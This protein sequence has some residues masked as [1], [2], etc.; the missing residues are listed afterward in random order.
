MAQTIPEWTERSPADI[1]VTVVELLAFAADQL[2]YYQ[3]SVANETY[4]GTARRRPSLRRHARLLDYTPREG[5]N[6]RTF[7]RIEV[8][9]ASSADGAQLPIHTPL[10][11]K[12][13]GLTTT[14]V[15]AAAIDVALQAGSQVFE[16]MESIT[17]H[18]SHDE[19]SIYTWGDEDCCLPKGAV[20]ATLLNQDL[21]V[22]PLDSGAIKVGALLAF[23][24]VNSPNEGAPPDPQHRH[25]VRLT[26]VRTTTDPLEGKQLVEIEWAPDDALP[27][28]LCVRDLSS[29]VPVSVVQGNI[30]LADHGHSVTQDLPPPSA[31]RGNQRFLPHLLEGPI[32]FQAQVLDAGQNPILF[33]PT[34]PATAALRG[35]PRLA[36]PAVLLFP[37]RSKGPDNDPKCDRDLSA[38]TD[39]WTPVR[40]LLES[41]PFSQSF[42]VE[43]ENDGTA[44]LRFGDDILGQTPTETLFACYRVG[45]GAAGNIGSGGLSHIVVDLPGIVSVSNVVAATGG[46]D[47]EPLQ[48]IQLNAPQAFRVQERAVTPADYTDVA[49]R[50]PGVQRAVATLRFTGSWY[51]MFV[52]VDRLGG[53]PVDD[54]FKVDFAN[55]LERFRLAGYDLEIQGAIPVPLDVKLTACVLPGFLRSNVKKALL[56]ALSNRDLPDGRRGF[57]HPDNFTFGQPVFLSQLVAVALAVPGVGAIDTGGDNLVFKRLRRLPDAASG[58]GVLKMQRLE[59]AQL[60]NDPSQPEH[61]KLAL[62]MQGGGA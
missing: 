62:V 47:P 53:A 1:G 57:F 52:A 43:M 21:I 7:V 49:K 33:D 46:E 8:A 51:T 31:V 22:D 6:A 61:G 9:P 42:V 3:D 50:H 13:D 5:A 25:V 59:I 18:G 4:L 34:A 30:V 44:Q 38:D 16:T 27:F 36:R 11:S 29:G 41:G 14:T 40:D 23:V 54:A 28:P 48:E 55:F 60:D 26:R 39:H 10:L 24:E 15:G 20:R 19:I 17:L 56:D 45:N 37:T 2:S 58:Q 32:T 12:T 35:D